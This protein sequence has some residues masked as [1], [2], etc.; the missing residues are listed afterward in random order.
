MTAAAADSGSSFR[1][2]W[3]IRCLLR[4]RRPPVHRRGKRRRKGVEV[5]AAVV[6][7]EGVVAAAWSGRGG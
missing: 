7:E 3:K 2:R 5:E 1:G 6:E 4:H